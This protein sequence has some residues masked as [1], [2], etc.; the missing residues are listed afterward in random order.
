MLFRRSYIPVVLMAW[1]PCASALAQSVA[2]SA[3]SAS[4]TAGATAT[5]SLSLA[6]AAGAQPVSLQWTLAY[7][8]TDVSSI[9]VVA[10]GTAASTGKSVACSSGSG[11]ITC[12]AYGMNAAVIADGAVAQ[13]VATLSPTTTA[14]STPIQLLNV[15]ASDASGLA[16]PTSGSGA[17]LAIAAGSLAGV[18][19]VS[20]AP[21]TITGAGSVSCTVSLNG[22]APAGGVPVTLSSNNP[23]LTV[24]A[25]VSVPAG[26]VSA[27]FTAAAAAVASSQLVSITA[28]A[29]G[30]T[31]SASVTLSAPA[32]LTGFSCSP[33]TVV[34]GTSATCTVTLSSPA[35]AGGATVILAGGVAALS[36]PSS[37]TVAAAATTGTFA[38]T[39]SGS[40]TQTVLLTASWAGTSV[41][42]SE[43]VT[44]SLP[45]FTLLGNA[46]EV[47]GKTNGSTVKPTS[48]PAGL[49]GTVVVNGGSVN[50]APDQSGN[51][52]YFAACCTN[53]GNAYYKFTGAAIGNIFNFTQGQVAFS[54]TSRNNLAQRAKAS[55]FRSVFDVR[56]GNPANHLAY[57][58]TNVVSGRLI[59]FYTVGTA[60][61]YY[62]VPQGTED[63][64]FGSGV[65]MLVTM[66]W[67]GNALSLYLNGKLVNTTAYLAP[68]PNWTNAS[69]F[70]IG[71]YEYMTYGGYDSLDDILSSFTAGPIGQQQP[72][73]AGNVRLTGISCLPANITGAGVISCTVSLNAAAPAGGFPVALASNNASLT[74]PAAV[75]VPAG[76]VSAAFSAA[77]AA[78]AANQAVSITASA[79]GVTQPA[80]VTL[81]AAMHV[82]GISCSPA[83]IT[84]AGAISCTVS[85]SAAA[86]AGGFPVALAS[87]NASLTVPAAVTVPAGSVSAAFSAAATAVAAN[88]AVSITASANG[89]TQAASIALSAPVQL[90]GISCSPVAITG[91]TTVSCTISLSAPAPAAGFPVAL[92]SN[93]VCIHVP[94]SLT[95]PA[96][97]A[98]A[99]VPAAVI[100]VG[101]NRTV[102]ITASANTVTLTASIVLSAPLITGVSCSPT[103]LTGPGT[104][105]CTLS[106]N[107]PA[108]AGGFP[109]TLSSNNNSLTVPAGVTV[110]TGAASAAF[111]AAAS[112]VA[113]DQ[114]VTITSTANGVTETAS[115][116]VAA[117]A[118]LTDLSCSPAKVPSGTSSTCT[119]TLSKAAPASGA[120]ATLSGGVAVLAVPPS[121][122][123][124]AGATTATF[125]VTASGYVTQTVPL[126]ASWQGVSASFTAT[127]TPPP[128]TFSLLGNPSEAGPVANGA[129]ITPDIAPAGLT[130]TVVINGA[131]TV[132]FA[133]DQSGNGVYFLACCANNNNAYYKFTGAAV[134]QIFNF[135]QGQVSFTLQSRS[136]L[137]QR[138]AASSYRAVFDLR[139]DNPSNHIAY[140]ETLASSGHLLFYYTVNG[141]NQYYYVPAGTENTLFG[142]GISMVVTITWTG[143][144]LNLYLNGSLVK[145]TAY[146]APSPNWTAASVFDIGAYE[147]QIYGGYDSCDDI[148]SN[149]AVGPLI[150]Q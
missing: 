75:T 101:T 1:L 60:S 133:P 73:P 104:V 57:F 129:P 5:F 69:V 54:L 79:N 96:G 126:S 136:D 23:S 65:T 15:S 8:T 81:S 147:Y 82:T 88:Q 84:G 93:D 9:S 28:S 17:S 140:F 97:S 130:G 109:V 24:P 122:T 59:F 29:N 35:P 117:P 108:P 139:D 115:V 70:D 18:S 137:A 61:A 145:S 98:S 128:P 103:S 76:S 111:S 77:A 83:N 74:V 87:N 66:S 63:S 119:V 11:T 80:S 71:G 26:A 62:Y 68:T 38:A 13:V 4:G 42:F 3:T 105:S 91:D 92:S 116:T 113:S 58:Q 37:V 114:F 25:S 94:A 44:P 45:P 123:V 135:A 142:N 95:V 12:L 67:T 149:F 53:N 48:G 132:N 46:S 138:S 2:L 146:S 121:V 16:I 47:S 106:L 56:D 49:T 34:I 52:V 19:G 36:I 6:S 30:L 33:S 14:A 50:F 90:T 120:T 124:A 55:S 134:G 85:L 7:S 125:S 27:N 10:A 144:T 112:A 72:P 143:N 78:V 150:Q 40:S 100:T 107:I 127:V 22:A 41:S 148:I 20:C 64:L 110:A 141:A 31:Q 118:K 21:A 131:G 86:P 51:G 39:A 32:Q 99:T 102:S 89:L 43:T